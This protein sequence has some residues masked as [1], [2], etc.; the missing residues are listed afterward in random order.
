MHPGRSPTVST[1]R[2]DL[3]S[4]YCWDT[5]RWASLW[6]GVHQLGCA[7]C[8]I[9]CSAAARRSQPL[10]TRPAHIQHA[11]GGRWRRLAAAVA[12]SCGG[13]AQGA[14]LV[15][16]PS[17]RCAASAGACRQCVRGPVAHEPPWRRRRRRDAGSGAAGPYACMSPFL[18]C[19]PALPAPRHKSAFEDIPLPHSQPCLV[20]IGGPGERSLVLFDGLVSPRSARQHANPDSPKPYLLTCRAPACHETQIHGGCLER[21]DPAKRGSC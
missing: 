16:P 2:L 13:E 9:A 6:P 17:L 14:A 11:E 18:F 5:L 3:P 12:C 19:R 15:V 8:G 21:G 10:I 4:S 1:Q 7:H 20:A